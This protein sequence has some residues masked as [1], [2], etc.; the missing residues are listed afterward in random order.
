MVEIADKS[1]EFCGG[2]HIDN[3]AKLGLFRIVS[4][5]SVAAGVR[6]IEGLTGL[7]VLELLNRDKSLMTETAAA[8][9]ASNVADIASRAKQLG[10]ELKEAQKEISK[11]EAKLAGGKVDEIVKNA[12]SVGNV[13]L[14]TA[15]FKD[16]TPDELRN[17]AEKVKGDHSD[18]V[19]ALGGTNGEKVTFCVTCGADSIKCGAH[20]GN[21]VREIAKVAE[22]NGGGKPDSAMAGGKNVAK[23]GA[24]IDAAK[25]ILAT[26]I[27]A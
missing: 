25:D 11:L 21:L 9:K 12:L 27:G 14:V 13:K 7:N 16:I 19:C 15:L 20:A 17:M 10:V 24:A 26:M 3:T 6:R 8:L 22:G 5:S 1:V 4:E 2:T 23:A 18:F